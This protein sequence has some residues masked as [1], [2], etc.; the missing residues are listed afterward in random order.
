LKRARLTVPMDYNRPL[1][2]SK[3]N[4]KV[5]LALVLSLAP[6]RTEDPASYGETSLLVN[7]GGPGGSG[8]FFVAT[9][10][11]SLRNI[12]GG[13]HDI[14]GF[15][16]R[17]I[18]ASTPRADCYQSPDM[19]PI[20]GEE[21]G[22]INRLAWQVGAHEVGLVNSSQGALVMNEAR[23]RALTQL[24]KGVSDSH[25]NESIF[26]H[27]NT[28]NVAQDMLSIIDAWDAWRHAS[29]CQ[30]KKTTAGH[31]AQMDDPLPSKLAQTTAKTESPQSLK[32]KARI[33]GF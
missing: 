14:L 5:H 31:D 32:R 30:A 8:A 22:F 12:V 16:P 19:G 6:G 10:N 7:P 28:A 21:F 9:A 33:L 3:A 29:P 17:G 23:S 4:P 11:D 27:V 15:D 1:N 13:D 18:A 25:G 20:L 2:E 26:R 24:C